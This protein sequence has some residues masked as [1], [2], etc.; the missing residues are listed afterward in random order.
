MPQIIVSLWRHLMRHE[1]NIAARQ[2]LIVQTRL[3]LLPIDD[4]GKELFFW[5][6]P[7]RSPS[8]GI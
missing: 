7:V 2:Q 4:T 3:G 6:V 5:F 1:R 8:V